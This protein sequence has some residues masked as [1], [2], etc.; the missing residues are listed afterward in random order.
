[1]R[2]RRDT[3]EVQKI[4]RRYTVDAGEILDRGMIYK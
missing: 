3:G 2:H 1:M 4:Y